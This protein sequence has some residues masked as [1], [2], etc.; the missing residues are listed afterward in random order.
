MSIGVTEYIFGE[1]MGEL[2]KRAD[3]LLY[4]AKEDGHNRICAAMAHPGLKKAGKSNPKP[5]ITITA[6]SC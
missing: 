5:A 4:K 3:S 2:V 1:S 6:I